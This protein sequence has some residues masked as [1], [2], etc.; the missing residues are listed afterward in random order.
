MAQLFRG[1]SAVFALCIH[2]LH[3]CAG[4]TDCGPTTANTVAPDVDSEAR[5]K[6]SAF[7]VADASKLPAADRTQILVLATPHLRALACLTPDMAQPLIDTL[8]AWRPDIVA[9]EAL[10]GASVAALVARSDRFAE[11]MR[12]FTRM[13]VE[14]GSL[15]RAGLRIDLNSARA[16]LEDASEEGRRALLLAI[17]YDYPSAV[18]AWSKLSPTQR[19]RSAVPTALQAKFEETLTANNEIYSIAVPVAR[20][21]GLPRLALVDDFFGEE[22]YAAKIEAFSREIRGNREVERVAS[23]PFYADSDQRLAATCGSPPKLLAYYRWMNTRD[24]ARA[25][26][27]LQWGVWFRTRLRSGL[28]RARYAGWEARNLAIAANIRKESSLHPGKRVLV[29]YGAAHKPF[30]DTYLAQLADVDVVQ[31]G[32]LPVC[33]DA[34]NPRRFREPQI[35]LRP[36]VHRFHRSLEP[37]GARD[38]V[39]GRPSRSQG[40]RGQDKETRPGEPQ[41]AGAGTGP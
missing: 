17:V 11:N 29:V 10:P 14:A 20:V 12:P 28:D 34:P 4:A 13:A 38:S 3:G 7:L 5:A 1:G 31:L 22:A 32:D 26:I 19:A 23:A 2:S 16:E 39:R 27:A 18:L 24:Y 8:V 33:A 35:L 30:L 36:D 37:R 9:V 25:D 6:P 21:L 41:H 40:R 15:A